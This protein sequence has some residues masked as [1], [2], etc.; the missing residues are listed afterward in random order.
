[1]PARQSPAP[2][3]GEAA[4]TVRLSRNLVKR[5]DRWIASHDGPIS[6]S[7]ALRHLAESGLDRAGT[8][9]KAGASNRG[10]KQAAGMASDMIDFLGDRSAT[11]EDR[12]H[13]KKRLV[14]GPSEFREIRE[15]E[16]SA[17]RKR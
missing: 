5:I 15:K 14:K 7:E 4:I 9:S 1:M 10:A 16:V 8:S 17:R 11:H 13:R 2:K 12:E 3:A 6:R